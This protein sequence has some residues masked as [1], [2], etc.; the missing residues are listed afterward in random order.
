MGEASVLCDSQTLV[1][2]N[3][4][5]LVDALFRDRTSR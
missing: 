1:R 2:R 3:S 5:V 4:F